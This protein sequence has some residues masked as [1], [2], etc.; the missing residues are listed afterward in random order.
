[1]LNITKQRCSDT[2][3][4]NLKTCKLVVSIHYRVTKY[5]KV[6]YIINDYNNLILD[7]PD[8]LITLLNHFLSPKRTGYPSDRL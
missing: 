1:M 4:K 7:L 6:N 3:Q 5:L 8:Q 2:S